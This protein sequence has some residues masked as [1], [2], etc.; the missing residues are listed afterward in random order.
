M[1]NEELNFSIL[2]R[3]K[4]GTIPSPTD[5]NMNLEMWAEIIEY[6]HDRNYLSNVSIYW[7]EA[8]DSYYEETVHSV[9]LSQAKITTDGLKFLEKE[10]HN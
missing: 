3:I 9:D 5:Y 4:R 6:L 2:N 7:F 10:I 8:D 1:N